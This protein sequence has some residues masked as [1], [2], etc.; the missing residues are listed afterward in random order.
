VR[1]QAGRN[2]GIDHLD[3]DAGRGRERV[4]ARP[5][6]KERRDHRSRDARRIARHALFGEPMVAREHQEHDALDLRCEAVADQAELH[7][8]VLDAAE[9]SRRFRLAV[10]T[11]AQRRLERAVDRGNSWMCHPAPVENRGRVDHAPCHR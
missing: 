9:R 4:H 10:D 11:R 2:A 7:R 8:E 3:L 5:S 1:R 6:G